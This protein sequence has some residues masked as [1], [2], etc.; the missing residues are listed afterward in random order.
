ML[1]K[2]ERERH[3]FPDMMLTLLVLVLMAFFYHGIHALMLAA[4]CA[5]FS[6]AAEMI[7]VKFL[8][9]EFRYGD[10]MC[11]TDGIILSLMMPA[12]M[13]Y[14]AAAAGSVFAVVCAKNVFGGRKNMI[15]SPAA[16]GY[17]FMLTSWKKDMLSFPET[18]A[19]T[20]FFAD[21]E[22]LASSAS[23]IYN[24]T[25]RMEHTGYEILMGSFSGPMGGVSIL[26]L[27][28]AAAVLILRK[29]ISAGAFAGTIASTVL[30]AAIAAEH[31]TKMRTAAI[32][33]AM[34]MVLFA[35][36]YIVSD[37]RLAP[38]KAHFAFFYGFFTAA[39]A[40]ILVLTMAKE[41]AIVIVSVLMAPAA[42]GF[43]TLE[44][45][46]DILSAEEVSAK[47]AE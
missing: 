24:T 42:L 22:G 40:Y 33:V 14:R 45:K 10:L 29:D 2:A 25:G 30:F 47:E 44:D 34:N 6:L 36:V 28:I 8:G 12:S 11:I 31:G 7:S 20:G 18:Y 9:R 35:A 27:M 3:T 19:H 21:T 23:H 32:A 16:A 4:V 15:F 41:N 13:A 38:R 37:K 46:I 1:K 39:A 17:I 43:R 26:L 5:A